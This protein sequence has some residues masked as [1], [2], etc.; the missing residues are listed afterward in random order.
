[1]ANP[2]AETR[3]VAAISASIWP[4]R[5]SVTIRSSTSS[6][7]AKNKR[8][9]V[10][11]PYSQARMIAIA[12]ARRPPGIAHLRQAALLSAPLS[13]AMSAI[14]VVHLSCGILGLLPLAARERGGVR[15]IG[16]IDSL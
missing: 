6:G 14:G 13:I 9:S 11:A 1:M 4:L 10:R 7:G 15:G 8:P 5:A 2:A 12:S 3:I 16:P